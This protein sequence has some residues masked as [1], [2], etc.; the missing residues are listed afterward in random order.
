LKFEA[1]SSGGVGK[2]AFKALPALGS[3]TFKKVEMGHADTFELKPD[4]AGQRYLRD[5]IKAGDTILIVAVPEDEEVAATLFGAG[6][7]VVENRPRLSI[8]SESAK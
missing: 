7:E 4:E 6:A 2:D 8:E 1:G 3:G 5:W